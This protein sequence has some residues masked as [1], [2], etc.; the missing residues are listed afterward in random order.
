VARDTNHG[1]RQHEWPA[2]A[3]KE[4]GTDTEV[5]TINATLHAFALRRKAAEIIAA[6]DSVD[7]DFTGSS[8]AWG[9]GGGRDLSRLVEDAWDGHADTTL[10]GRQRLSRRDGPAS[11]AGCGRPAGRRGR[12]A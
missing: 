10:P 7:L 5:A 4:L 9:Y 1:R 2:A 8:E 11:D 3:R 6:F 12:S